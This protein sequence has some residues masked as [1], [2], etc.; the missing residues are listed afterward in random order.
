MVTC[1]CCMSRRAKVSIKN[2]ANICFT[3]NEA[4]MWYVGLYVEEKQNL[5]PL[6][7]KKN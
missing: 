1:E 4:I 7:Q 2:K 6:S 3:C 5:T